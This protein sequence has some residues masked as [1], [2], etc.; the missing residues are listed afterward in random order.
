MTDPLGHRGQ[1]LAPTGPR[2][3][4][5]GRNGQQLLAPL[6]SPA[7]TPEFPAERSSVSPTLIL[8]RLFGAELPYP[9][10]RRA[11]DVIVVLPL[12]RRGRRT[13]LRVVHDRWPKPQR[14]SLNCQKLDLGANQLAPACHAE[15]SGRPRIPHY[16]RAVC[17]TPR[18]FG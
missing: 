10:R 9:T 16:F 15:F 18:A 8:W 17:A 14:V 5:H 7:P 11:L 4:R 1:G 2:S 12:W 3:V 6:L 13:T